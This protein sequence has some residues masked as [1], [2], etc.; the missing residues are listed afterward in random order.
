M[1]DIRHTATFR[2]GDRHVRRIGY[3]AMQLAG[4]GVFGPPKDREA[5]LNVLR[6]AV[7]SGVDHLDTSDF[8]G[9]HVTNQLIR[10]ALHPY[11]DDLVIVTKIGAR[12][13]D[14]ASWLP[15]FAPDELERAVHDNLRNLGLDVLDVVNLRIMF[16]THGPAEGSI[17]APLATLAELQRRGLVRHIGLSNVTPAQ[18]AQGRR[19]CDIVCVQNHYNIAHRG[20]DALIDTLA[21][22][23]IAYVPY[24]P[25]GGFSPLQSSTLSGVAA[26]LGATPM[27]VALAWLLRRAPNLLLIPGTSSVAHLRENLASADLDLPADALAALN[28]IAGAA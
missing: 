26:R 22:D 4:P 7:E 9:P 17:E 18:V 3:G 10:D 13:G 15:A 19:I 25:L 5:A 1:P 12:R 2:L 14:D 27:Q 11:R 6:E 8:Y 21:R 20:D 28:G 24:F 16:D 23:G